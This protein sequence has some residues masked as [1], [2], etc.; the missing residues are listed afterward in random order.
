MIDPNYPDRPKKFEASKL[1]SKKIDALL[2]QGKTLLKI[3]RIGNSKD[4]SYN[5]EAAD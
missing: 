5:V 2:G 4:T 1:T 3:T